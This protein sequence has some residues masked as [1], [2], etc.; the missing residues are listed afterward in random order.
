M[1]RNN[2]GTYSL[3]AGNPVVVGSVIEADWANPTM[4]DIANE[5]TASLPRDGSAPMIGPLILSRDA[6]LDDEPITKSQFDTALGGS[7]NYLPAG[8]VQAFA[9]NAVPTG[10]LKCNGA[11][12]SRTTYADLFDAIGTTYGTGNGTT[13]FTLPDLRGSFVRG[14]DESRGVDTART[15]GTTQTG[16]NQSH[17]HTATIT[18]PAHNHGITD[19]G[20]AHGVT[21]PGHTHDV[22]S[23]FG[24][25]TGTLG[26]YT[27]T[28]AS[29]PSYVGGATT[30]ISINL[31]GTG[32][33]VNN[34][35]QAT[36][37]SIANEGS[38]SRPHNVAMIYCIKA[39]GAVQSDGLGNLVSTVLSGDTD[40]LT[41]DDTDPKNII[42]EP[43][44]NVAN[45]LVK[46]D[47]G[48][49]MPIEHLPRVPFLYGATAGPTTVTTNVSTKMDITP[50]TDTYQFWDAVNKR[51][52]PEICGYYEIRV[53]V[54]GISSTNTLEVCSAQSAKN[55]TTLDNGNYIYTPTS[56]GVSK[57][58]SENTLIIDLNGTTDYLEPYVILKGGGTLTI[59][60]YS[61]SIILID[62][63]EI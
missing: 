63:V 35:T 37:A 14:L 21:D 52:T 23:T 53:K 60:D 24:P 33:S 10:W 57:A 16:A 9:M 4:S 40:V 7:N 32:I 38:E 36:T 58:R 22:H 6:E 39:F 47:S 31:N 15:L 44:T 30:G 5:I 42:L 25:N 61:L 8:A 48:A 12:V 28:D 54:T 46:M 59:E 17:T 56:A 11:A 13:T 45:G 34:A 55:G 3:P 49:R 26:F 18:N 62:A 50:S 1:P 20:H 41:I 27:G 29:S 2:S 19:P 51:Y 43:V